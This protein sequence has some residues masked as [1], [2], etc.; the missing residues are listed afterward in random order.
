MKLG[1]HVVD[2]GLLDKDGR[3]VG[4]VDD[5]ILEW[6]EAGEGG[7]EVVALVSGPTA[8]SRQFSAPARRLTRALYRLLG[9]PDPAPAVIPWSQVESIEVV[10]NLTVPRRGLAWSPVG[11]AV[12]RRF[13]RRLPWS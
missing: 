4:K 12:N 2:R 3:R 5:L 9:V 8:L 1:K 10:I 7:P 11:N 6:D 13:I